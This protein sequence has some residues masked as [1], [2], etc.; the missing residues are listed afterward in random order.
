MLALPLGLLAGQAVALGAL[1]VRDP[2]RAGSWGG[3]PFLTLTG[4]PCPWCGGLRSVHDLVHGDVV[5]A[6]SSNAP[7]VL[8]VLALLTGTIAWTVV[9][10]RARRRGAADPVVTRL[11]GAP[12]G[13]WVAAVL[14][15]WCAFG[16]AR[17][18]APLAWWQP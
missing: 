9:A 5:A 1:A 3:C 6:L 8:A 7:T 15:L 12:V 10:W 16:V 4:L 11:Q 17:W 18:W 14:L 2:H 13:R